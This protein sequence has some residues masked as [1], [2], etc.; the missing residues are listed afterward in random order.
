QGGMTIR[1]PVGSVRAQ[2]RNTLGVRIIR[3]EPGDLVKDAVALDASPEGPEEPTLP[4]DGGE[5]EAPGEGPDPAG[6]ADPEQGGDA[7]P[8]PEG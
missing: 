8:P 6:G 3:I 4:G 5:T 1:L 7:A 2:G